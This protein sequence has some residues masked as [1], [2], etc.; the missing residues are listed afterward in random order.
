MDFNLR[1]RLKVFF[2]FRISYW[3]YSYV[4]FIE[5]ENICLLFYKYLEEYVEIKE[6]V[7]FLRFVLLFYK[8][9]WYSCCFKV[10]YCRVIINDEF[11][12]DSCLVKGNLGNIFLYCVYILIECV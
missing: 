11:N 5:V 7:Y 9:L 6:I 3:I 8:F 12:T 4:I 1:F 2:I 10:I